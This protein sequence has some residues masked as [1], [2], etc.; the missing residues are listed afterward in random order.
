MI[1]VI[2]IQN[3]KFDLRVYLLL[4][5]PFKVLEP[6]TR[7]SHKNPSASKTLILAVPLPE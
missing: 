5:I 2:S 7:G 1:I 3:V 4:T 6:T